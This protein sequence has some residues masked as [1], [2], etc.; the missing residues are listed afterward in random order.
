MMSRL[1][2]TTFTSLDGVMQAP[3]G[4]HED[5]SGG[6]QLGGWIM[7]HFDPELGSFIESVFRRADAFLL[8]RGTWEIFS[9]HWPRVKDPSD[10]VAE[11]LNGRPK[12]VVSRRLESASRWAGS[13]LVRDPLADL[14]SLLRTYPRELQVH[15]SPGLVRSLLAAGVVDELN[16]MQFPVVL[17]LGKRWLE[18]AQPR[19]LELLSSARTSKGVVISRYRFAGEV[20]LADVPGPIE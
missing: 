16:L 20:L 15:G 14:P 1:T 7:P 11:A 18:A 17:G 2:V 19:S 3:G 13:T 12:H 9:G 8:G 10:P 5:P 4:R 6:F